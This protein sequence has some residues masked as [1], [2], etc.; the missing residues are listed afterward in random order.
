M[1]L[2]AMQEGALGMM[3]RNTMFIFLLIAL[4]MTGAGLADPQPAGNLHVTSSP[5]LRVYVDDR[6]VGLTTAEHGGLQVTALSAGKHQVRVEKTGFQSQR[7]MV[8]IQARADVEL[9]VGKLA[10]RRRIRR[11]PPEEPVDM[12]VGSPPMVVDDTSTPGPGNWDLNLVF[13]GD[14]STDSD[15]YDSPL[16]DINNGR[17][18]NV[19]FK[20]EVPYVF[21]RDVQTDEV[22]N[23]ET[24]NAHGVADPKVGVKYRFYDNDETALSLAVY[25]QVKFKF[26]GAQSTGSGGVA[27]A[28]TTWFLPLLLTKDFAHV[29]ITANAEVDKST[30]DPHAHL[31]A[32]FGVGTRLTDRL[33]MLGEL[34]GENLDSA[35]EERILFDLGLHLKLSDRHAL[36]AAMG[37]DVEAG[38]G[39]R[40]HYFT[41]GYQKSIGK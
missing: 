29:S 18:E 1:Y 40:H 6:F 19:Q 26:P 15:T 27:D 32:G 11:K 10:V 16:V 38:D 31:F 13:T 9:K 20:F 14:L 39:Q 28:G 37:V 23:Q 33:A 30:D 35:G 34:A 22:G 36:V 7:F 12:T 8:V 21:T 17:G 5:G 41:V 2:G 3:A 24:V 4:A 25:P